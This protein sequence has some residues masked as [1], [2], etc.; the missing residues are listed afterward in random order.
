MRHSTRM[1]HNEQAKAPEK[2]TPRPDPVIQL[3]RSTSVAVKR[4]DTVPVMWGVPLQPPVTPRGQG[5]VFQEKTY[6]ARK[7]HARI[8]S[9]YNDETLSPWISNRTRGS[10]N[11]RIAWG[12][13]T[14]RVRYTG[15]H[16]PV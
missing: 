9:E 6:F 15:A 7:Q 2:Q 8:T 12:A 16:P 13:G 5:W 14:A 3:F 10:S 1:T 4:Y 11:K